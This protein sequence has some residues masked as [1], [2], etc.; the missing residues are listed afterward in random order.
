MRRFL[1]FLKSK[2]TQKY[3]VI[4]IIIEILTLCGEFSNVGRSAFNFITET[5]MTYHG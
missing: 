3:I 2:S 1:K 5:W 4:V